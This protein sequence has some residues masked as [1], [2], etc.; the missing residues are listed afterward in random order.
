[1]PKNTTPR[2]PKSQGTNLDELSGNACTTETNMIT[3]TEPANEVTHGDIDAMPARWQ[4]ISIIGHLLNG[5]L[6]G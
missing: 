5:F 1:M 3:A 2:N 6:I 4:I